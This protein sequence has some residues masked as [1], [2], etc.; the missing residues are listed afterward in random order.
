MKWV[1]PVDESIRIDDRVYITAACALED[2]NASTARATMREL[3]P[4]PGRRFH[5]HDR[6]PADRLAAVQAIAQL[7]TL[8]VVTIGA[9]ID[10]R[11]QERA[12]RQCLEALLFHLDAAGVEQVWLETRNATADRRDIA[13]IDRFR[14]R[15]IIGHSIRVDHARPSAEPL[16][17]LA[18]AVAGAV[19]A[20]EGGDPTYRAVIAPMLTEHRIQLD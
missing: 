15:Q 3:E 19:S 14:A 6:K 10:T 8:H 11:R 17:W 9:P 12:R 2:M 5:W 13:A 18:D 16:L 7:P 4:R 1:A 20:A